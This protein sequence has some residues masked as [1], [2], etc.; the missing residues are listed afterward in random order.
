MRLNKKLLNVCFSIC[1]VISLVNSFVLSNNIFELVAWLSA[2]CFIAISL[3]LL[4][5]PE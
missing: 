5:K 2:S 1:G 3:M 4:N